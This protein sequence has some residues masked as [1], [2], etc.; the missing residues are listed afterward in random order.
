MEK[1]KALIKNKFDLKGSPFVAISVGLL[2]LLESRFS[3]R[4]RSIS[5]WKRLKTNA[6][7]AG[8]AALG[9]RLVLIPALVQTSV[10]VSKKNIG[11]LQHLKLPPFF[12]H[13]LTFLILDYGNYR[14]H[15]LNHSSPVLWKFHQVH[16]SDLDLDVSTAL[17][18][19]IGEML[20]SVFYRAA[21]ITGTG[22]TPG[23]VLFY[24]VVF[25]AA[26][27]FH[28]S[29]LRLPE[30]AD[31]TLS[32][33]IVTP[34]MHGIH[35][36]IVKEETDSNFCIIFSF[37][38]R[39]HRT[40]KLDIPQEKINIGVPYIRHHQETPELLLMPASPLP[41]WKLPDGQVPVRKRD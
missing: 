11:L 40:M 14:W 1:A 41:E 27:G 7:M 2:F 21:W 20:A 36:S 5:K 13:L 22:A 35:H 26:T 37:W 38:D 10:L 33:L 12:R 39:L 19:H 9:L 34:R 29:N 30:K 17:R 16:H 25:E 32:R 6:A 4:K 18:F 23:T 8:T 28:H 24:E 15:K 31:R 3:L